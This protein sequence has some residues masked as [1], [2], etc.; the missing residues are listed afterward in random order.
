[1]KFNLYLINAFKTFYLLSLYLLLLLFL[2]QSKNQ[3][4]YSWYWCFL[5]KS[6]NWTGF[7]LCTDAAEVFPGSTRQPANFHTVNAGVGTQHFSSLIYSRRSVSA[8]RT[9]KGRVIRLPLEE[10]RWDLVCMQSDV[11]EYPPPN[12]RIAGVGNS[13]RSK[14]LVSHWMC[15]HNT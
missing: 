12:H 14:T 9:R 1:M 7:P 3:W 15:N 13:E 2:F 5:T 4:W 11:V 8:G 6:S 10:H